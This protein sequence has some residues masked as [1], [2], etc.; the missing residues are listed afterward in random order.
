MHATMTRTFSR[1][2]GLLLLAS[3]VATVATVYS[4]GHP[5]D[6]LLRLEGFYNRLF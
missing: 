5:H 6:L 4:G 1:L 3:V 2:L